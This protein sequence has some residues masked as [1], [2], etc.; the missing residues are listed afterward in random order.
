MFSGLNA[1]ISTFVFCT[2]IDDNH[3]AAICYV[4]DCQPYIDESCN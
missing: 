2:T 4:R 1:K 3:Y